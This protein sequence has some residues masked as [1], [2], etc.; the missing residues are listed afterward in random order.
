VKNEKYGVAME[1]CKAQL[2][3]LSGKKIEAVVW[4]N[5]LLTTLQTNEDNK[6]DK[7]FL[8]LDTKFL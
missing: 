5:M 4:V 7:P 1:Q 6:E 8:Q 3:N 2:Q